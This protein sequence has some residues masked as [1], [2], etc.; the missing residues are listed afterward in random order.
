MYTVAE[1]I[2]CSNS[3]ESATNSQSI[4]KMLNSKGDALY[5]VGNYTEAIKYYDKVLEIQP[6]IQMH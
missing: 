5:D 4:V 1:W 2:S 3:D 6:M